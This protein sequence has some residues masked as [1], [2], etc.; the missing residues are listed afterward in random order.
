M[1]GCHY[2]LKLLAS[3]FL[4]F[5]FPQ[6]WYK[7]KVEVT[8]KISLLYLCHIRVSCMWAKILVP[9]TNQFTTN[10]QKHTAVKAVP[11]VITNKCI[12]T[13]IQCVEIII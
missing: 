9:V 4:M 3:S 1:V 12:S 13:V 7:V 10:F 2:F 11:S 6:N 8:Y 5:P